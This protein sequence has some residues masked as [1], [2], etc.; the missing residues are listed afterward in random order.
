MSEQKELLII[1]F[2][3]GYRVDTNG[4]IIS[5]FNGIIKG[6][7]ALNGRYHFYIRKT[8]KEY[9]KA[10]PVH[11]LQAYQKFGNKM[12]EK[13]IVVRHLN[14]NPLDNSWTNIEIGTQLENILDRSKESLKEHSLKASRKG[15]DNIRTYEERCKIYGDL[16]NGISYSEI[17]KKYNIT[18]KGT[19]SFMKN[20]SIE[21][22]EFIEN[23]K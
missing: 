10:V 5:P 4:N 3:K 20:K 12:F 9:S 1:A 18:S 13:G 17:M 23:L 19:L 7:V 6:V 11:R 8:K 21:Y 16:K 22:K 2:E 15:Q 14:G